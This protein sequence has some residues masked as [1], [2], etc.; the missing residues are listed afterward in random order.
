MPEIIRGREVKDWCGPASLSWAIH[1]LGEHAEQGLIASLAGSDHVWGTTGEG[2]QRSAEELGYTAHWAQVPLETLEQKR[3]EGAS[4]I[5][6]FMD[7]ENEQED[8]HYAVLR[9]L[10]PVW[11]VLDDPSLD[12]RITIFRR[13]DFEQ[14]WFDVTEE[15]EKQWGWAMVVQK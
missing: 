13:N 12:G 11:I 6:N 2:L 5:I 10:T 14:R 9:K 3:K 15:G 1:L 7:G 4:I 8:G